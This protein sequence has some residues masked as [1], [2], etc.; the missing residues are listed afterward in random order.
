VTKQRHH[1]F[2][3][4][5]D[6][7]C[8]FIIDDEVFV[9]TGTTDVLFE[10]VRSYIRK[11]GKTLDLGCGSGVIG[12]AL[13]KNGLID[14]PVYASDL[15]NQAIAVAKKNA[16]FHHCPIVAK[17][18]SL[19]NPWQNDKFDYII[20]DVAGISEEIAEISPWY[21]QIPCR[22][23]IDGTLLVAEVLQNASDY[24][25]AG[26]LLFFPV[27]SFSNTKRILS[28]AHKN[29]LHVER[30]IHKE[31]PLPEEMVQHV[32]IL[33]MLR[34]NGHIDFMEKFGLII[35]FTDI[36]VAYHM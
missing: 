20:S 19:F 22:S 29:F 25:N 31:W 28:T 36:Y 15:S 12:I 5:R 6:K 8:P 1:Q 16:S 35:W 34:K 32:L 13:F 33:K 23:G 21:N 11:P 7:S 14:P 30:L 10:A 18:G 2:K 26:G 17:K 9:P 24:L 4:S 27:I 3:I